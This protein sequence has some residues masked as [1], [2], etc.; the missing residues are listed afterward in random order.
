MVLLVSQWLQGFGSFGHDN[1]D[2]K[3]TK[4]W[5]WL[6]FKVLTLSTTLKI[7]IFSSQ[8][9]HHKQCVLRKQVP[10]SS[11]ST[12][13]DR[14]ICIY[15]INSIEWQWYDFKPAGTTAWHPPFFAV[16][17]MHWQSNCARKVRCWVRVPMNKR[18]HTQAKPINLHSCPAATW[19]LAAHASH[20]IIQLQSL[21]MWLFWYF[22]A[23]E[24]LSEQQ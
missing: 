14:S 23:V 22:G 16:V 10:I 3:F 11:Y 5:D 24:Y 1:I 17:S 2:V 18:V 19:H 8:R 13:S 21:Q 7:G 6:A 12:Q 20:T 4:Y 9:N 15:K